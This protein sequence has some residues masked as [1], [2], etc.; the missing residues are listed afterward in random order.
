M[1]GFMVYQILK[2][3]NSRLTLTTLGIVLVA[4]LKKNIVGIRY[5]MGVHQTKYG[6]VG[7]PQ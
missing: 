4:L 2:A 3:V 7:V 1:I 5:N 6:L